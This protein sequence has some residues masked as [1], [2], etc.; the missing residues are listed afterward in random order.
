M[1]HSSNSASNK[2]R[3]RTKHQK[4]QKDDSNNRNEQTSP[5][6]TIA[7][8]NSHSFDDEI[9][10]EFTSANL[11]QSIHPTIESRHEN[12]AQGKHDLEQES[13]L[14]KTKRVFNYINKQHIKELQQEQDDEAEFQAQE[15]D[16]IKSASIDPPPQ[17]FKLLTDTKSHPQNKRALN[18]L[19][20][21]STLMLVLPLSTFAICQ[22]CLTQFAKWSSDA[23]LSYSGIAAAIVVNIVSIGFGIYAWAEPEDEE[24]AAVIADRARRKE[25][26]IRDFKQKYKA[27]TIEQLQDDHIRHDKEMQQKAHKRQE[28]VQ[29][30][31]QQQQRND[32]GKSK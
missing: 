25:L 1:A 2:V 8:N 10:S 13:E 12:Y 18:Q 19:I 28:E 26:A 9:E 15:R 27:T 17:F 20:V 21:A 30:Q 14:H 5:N 22:Y 6:A 31:Q 24:D 3:S 32:N 7:T 23:S 29:Q 16:A 11:A 4:T